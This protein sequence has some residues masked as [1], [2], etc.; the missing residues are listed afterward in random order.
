MPKFKHPADIT[1]SRFPANPTYYSGPYP[2]ILNDDDDPANFP[3]DDDGQNVSWSKKITGLDAIRILE[4]ARVCGQRTVSGIDVIA[5]GCSRHHFANADEA[6]SATFD[7]RAHYWL[8][9]AAPY[10]DNTFGDDM[11]YRAA[12]I[13]MHLDDAGLWVL[14]V[15]GSMEIEIFNA[16]NPDPFEG[17]SRKSHLCTHCT[18]WVYDA[19]FVMV[20]RR[21]R[22]DGKLEDC[23][24]ECAIM[25]Q[26]MIDDQEVTL[27]DITIVA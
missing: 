14:D 4:E 20:P 2:V 9:K 24:R 12:T 13:G 18:D 17:V 21:Y 27:E 19:G 22:L 25:N 3:N 10:S 23:C 8:F 1:D 26:H 11:V 16:F 5:A 15:P 6:E 7:S